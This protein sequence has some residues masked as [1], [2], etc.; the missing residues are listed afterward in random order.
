MNEGREL[1][2]SRKPDAQC[3]ANFVGWGCEAEIKRS[4]RK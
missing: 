4:G 1:E 2:T 3:S